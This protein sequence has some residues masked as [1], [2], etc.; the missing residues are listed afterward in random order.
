MEI[1]KK[2]FTLFEALVA[3]LVLILFGTGMMGL[4]VVQQALLL[5]TQHRIQAI[6]YARGVAD[7]LLELGQEAEIIDETPAQIQE[8]YLSDGE[9]GVKALTKNEPADL[10]NGTHTAPLNTTGSDISTD[11]CVLPDSY[12]KQTLKGKLSYVVDEFTIV[13]IDQWGDPIS[14]EAKRVEIIV[15][16]EESFPNTQVKKESL[17]IVA[18]Y[19]RLFDRYWQANYA[20]IFWYEEG[21][22][23]WYWY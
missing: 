5:Q 2:G 8:A 22:K 9:D 17:F 14:T 7:I 20:R 4:Y 6:D 10:K 13:A 1:R 18:Y 21:D 16:W 3:A 23:E 12:F 19:D 15:E 11:I